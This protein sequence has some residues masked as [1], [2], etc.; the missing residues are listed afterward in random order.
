MN[1]YPTLK[2]FRNGSPTDY[3]GTRKADGIISYM[4]KSVRVIILIVTC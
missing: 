1:G 3:A 2:V 4:T